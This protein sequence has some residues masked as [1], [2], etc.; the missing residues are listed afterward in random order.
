MSSET[1]PSAPRPVS[2]GTARNVLIVLTFVNLFNYIDRFVVAGLT[3]TLKNSELHLSDTKL[4]LLATAFLAVYALVSPRFGTLGDTRSR[5][6][7]I[8]FGVAVWSIATA[9]GGFAIGFASLFVA[10]AFVGVGEAA[11]GTIA[12]SVLADAFPRSRRGRVFA[13]FYTAI[14]VGGALGFLVASLMGE[15][16]RAAFFVAG[17]PGLALAWLLLRL[18]DPP[19]ST[20]DD[21]PVGHPPAAPGVWRHYM[22]LLQNRQ[23]AFTVFGYAAYTFALGGLSWWMVSFLE[24]VHHVPHKDAAGQVGLIVVATGLVGT[25]LGGW[26]GD[27]ILRYTKHAYLLV[28]GVATLIAA[29]CAYLALTATDPKVYLA[30]LVVAELM[31]FAS[32]GPVNS[33]I[34]NY[35]ASGE[36]ATAMAFSILVIHALGDVPSPYI[37]GALSDARSAALLSGIAVPSPA[38]IAVAES[39]GLQHAVLI[40]PV[41]ILISGIIWT[42]GGLRK[43]EVSTRRS[44]AGST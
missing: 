25:F 37:V 4:G 6:R 41:A 16:W 9:L 26:L 2:P 34:V 42:V 11:Y 1:T 21:D 30:A 40:L 31:I 22:A 12:P 36:R 5:P 7:V 38:Q 20:A 19:R 24:R 29:P 17:V 33:A 39:S 43:D 18:P 15:H 27:H 35:V 32:T 14:P 13:I 23:Y 8:A 3:E 44:A 10:R 28:S